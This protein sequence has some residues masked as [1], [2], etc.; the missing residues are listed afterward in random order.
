[1]FS[2]IEYFPV[3]V[4]ASAKAGRQHIKL[5]RI[6]PARLG[7]D[8]P[9]LSELTLERREQTGLRGALENLCEK[10]TA[11]RQNLCRE[12]GGQLD[13][14]DD[15]QMIRLTMAGGVAGHV[16]EDDIG[17][18]AEPFSQD[19]R[20]LRD[21]EIKLAEIDARNRFDRQKIDAEDFACALGRAN[22]G[23]SDLRPAA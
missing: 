21:K 13:Q 23:G 14:A 8:V 15:A 19:L 4:R 9:D 20:R 22:L 5:G 6:R 3:L 11:R 7:L 10:S 1:M 2:K 16:R 12:I 18:T 17:R